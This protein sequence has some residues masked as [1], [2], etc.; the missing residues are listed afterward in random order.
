MTAK[1]N[2]LLM[3]SDNNRY[4]W[5][6]YTYIWMMIPIKSMPLHGLGYELYIYVWYYHISVRELLLIVMIFVTRNEG[7]AGGLSEIM[8][9]DSDRLYACISFL[10]MTLH[11]VKLKFIISVHQSVFVLAFFFSPLI[12]LSYSS[13]LEPRTCF[14]ERRASLKGRR[15]QQLGAAVTMRVPPPFCSFACINS[16]IHSKASNNKVVMALKR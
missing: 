11:I 8:F 4:A 15:N 6:I 14:T 3:L 5:A 1:I 16:T 2:A 10:F 12:L 9:L 7:A 13:L